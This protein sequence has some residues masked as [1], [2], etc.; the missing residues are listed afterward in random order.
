MNEHACN[1]PRGVRAIN[2][3]RPLVHP[4]G[5][6]LV[7]VADVTLGTAAATAPSRPLAASATSPLRRWWARFSE[8]RAKSRRPD[9][10]ES[11]AMAREMYRL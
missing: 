1:L 4:E 11:A 5:T 10:L 7:S 2:L 9:Y 3:H 8:G 6:R